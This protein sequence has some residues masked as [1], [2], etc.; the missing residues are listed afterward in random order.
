MMKK[1]KIIGLVSV[2]MV[3][4]IG[5]PSVKHFCNMMEI[6][7]D[8]DCEL[9]CNTCSHSQNEIESCC[10]METESS[11]SDLVIS[12]NDECC[13]DEFTINKIDDEFI[14]NKVESSHKISQTERALDNHLIFELKYLSFSKS[15]SK[16]ASPRLKTETEVYILFH[17]L[18]I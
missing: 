11:I 15:H 3:S 1:I 8:S 2:I 10:S 5:I 4:M 16:D 7:K 14:I 17:S 6:S 13:S 18:L 9:I 12:V